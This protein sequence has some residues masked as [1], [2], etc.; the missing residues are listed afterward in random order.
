[1]IPWSPLARAADQ[2]LGSG[3]YADRIV[4]RVADIAT[5]RGVPRAQVALAWM[6]SKPV[7]TAPLVG[8]TKIGQIDDAVAALDLTLTDDEIAS[9]EEPYSPRPIAGFQ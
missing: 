1:M 8:V 7:V 9:L 5:A 2:G 4:R 6:L 3:Q